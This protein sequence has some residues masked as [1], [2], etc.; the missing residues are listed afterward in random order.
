MTEIAVA[1]GHTI[2]D[3][4]V[5]LAQADGDPLALKPAVAAETGAKVAHCMAAGQSSSA[6]RLCAQAQLGAAGWMANPAMPLQLWVAQRGSG[7][8]YRQAADDGCG[9][10]ADTTPT[11]THRVVSAGS[12]KKTLLSRRD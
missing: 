3:R 8:E 11:P 7:R 1:V 9:C 4:T 10:L 2:S 6:S 5:M 12:A